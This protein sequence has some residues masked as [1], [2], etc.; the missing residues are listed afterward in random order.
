MFDLLGPLTTAGLALYACLASNLFSEA[1]QWLP[2]IVDAIFAALTTIVSISLV[3]GL[4]ST[5]HFKLFDSK[6]MSSAE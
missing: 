4:D 1:N 3:V 5:I 6:M 2:R